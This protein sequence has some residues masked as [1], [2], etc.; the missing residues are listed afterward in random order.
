M[1]FLGGEIRFG[2]AI[3]IVNLADEFMALHEMAPPCRQYV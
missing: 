2:R 3:G 1:D